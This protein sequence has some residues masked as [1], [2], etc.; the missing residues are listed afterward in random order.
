MWGSLV[1]SCMIRNSGSGASERE[2][3][4]LAIYMGHSMDMQRGCYDRCVPLAY[5][6]AMHTHLATA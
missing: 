2:L 5:V 1:T 4:A 6:P 3:E